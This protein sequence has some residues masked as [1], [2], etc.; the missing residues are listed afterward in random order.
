MSFTALSILLAVAYLGLGAGY[1]RHLR[2]PADGTRLAL[3]A[4]AAL[5]GLLHLGL[6]PTAI[7]D[8]PALALGFGN[9]VSLLAAVVML[10]FVGFPLLR[11]GYN[12]G[13]ALAPLA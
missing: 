9:A 7:A 1:V 13:V 6:L 5:L 3:R 8:G 4:A 12:L 2:R 11:S 10:P